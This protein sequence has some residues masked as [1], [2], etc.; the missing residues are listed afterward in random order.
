MGAAG[1]VEEHV[2]EVTPANALREITGQHTTEALT[3]PEY[4]AIED[5]LIARALLEDLSDPHRSL[6]PKKQYRPHT[7]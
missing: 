2:A 6:P 7:P 5:E 4:P 3:I 1:E